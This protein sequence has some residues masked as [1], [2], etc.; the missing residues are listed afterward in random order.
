MNY[1]DVLQ[2]QRNESDASF[3]LV[4]SG[5]HLFLA[6]TCPELSLEPLLGELLNKSGLTWSTSITDLAEARK[7]GRV[8]MIVSIYV[9]DASFSSQHH[10]LS[11]QLS[12]Y[13]EVA[14]LHLTCTNDGRLILGPRF[15]SD[16]VL[17]YRCF[18]EVLN[19]GSITLNAHAL[20]A[21]GLALVA[22]MICLEVV[23]QLAD[24]CRPVGARTVSVYDLRAHTTSEIMIARM[25]GCS[26]CWP[27]PQGGRYTGRPRMG[28]TAFY[29]ECARLRPMANSVTDGFENLARADGDTEKCFH[30]CQTVDLRPWSDL[31]NDTLGDK[32]LP[33]RRQ[34]LSELD[35][36]QL[37]FLSFG[38]LDPSFRLRAERALPSAGNLGSTEAFFIV[39]DVA[40]VEPGIY[41][42]EPRHHRL[43]RL[44]TPSRTSAVDF[45]KKSGLHS[46]DDSLPEMVVVLSGAFAR[47]SLKY[48]AFGYRLIHFDAGVAL[49]RLRVT[50]NALGI[51]TIDLPAWDDGFLEKHLLLRGF[52]EPVVGAMAF[53][54]R[55][56]A[57]RISY[58]PTQL[59][60]PQ[61]PGDCFS[62]YSN[63][64]LLARTIHEHSRSDAS[65][66]NNI[67]V[68]V[69]SLGPPGH[70][71]CG[72]RSPSLS[73][74]WL[75]TLT[76]RSRRQFRSEVLDLVLAQRILLD[77]LTDSDLWST[78]GSI[79][80][81]VSL[82]VDSLPCSALRVFSYSS[83]LNGL[84]EGLTCRAST[85]ASDMF[86]DPS[87]AE[88]PVTF[89]ICGNVDCEPRR[90]RQLL[91]EA[92]RRAYNLM[93]SAQDYGLCG[94]ITGGIRA[95]MVGKVL[96]LN[97][98]CNTPLIAFVAGFDIQS[99]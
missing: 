43:A 56:P 86:V 40:N 57:S 63:P 69:I 93:S 59:A 19:S 66:T 79:K 47:I 45:I 37:S 13:N 35:L 77:S 51:D 74:I 38:R 24:K 39:R 87:F 96:G 73:D 34:A 83:D 33:Q 46:S 95:A 65:M 88:A 2:L 15:A 26:E 84:V 41:F 97:S 8:V 48:G 60:S 55:T 94:V 3:P 23:R 32:E 20:G 53:F 11:V 70:Q 54:A 25:S 81:F 89:W 92:G 62:P 76:R 75:S 78:E 31:Y 44:E 91:V 82:A 16:D 52:D 30:N 71:T 80:V 50:A 72:Q 21:K 36:A 6:I 61:I 49:R 85:S 10:L 22:A 14:W 28:L 90:Y 12:R 4:R 9:G 29:D 64:L 99:S 18:Q 7:A 42:Y 17:C 58:S 27:L 1:K 67:P 5:A 98:I 68:D